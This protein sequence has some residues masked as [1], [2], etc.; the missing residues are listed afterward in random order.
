MYLNGLP[1]YWNTSTATGLRSPFEV[2]VIHWEWAVP[3]LLVGIVLFAAA[4][5]SMILHA[6]TLAPDVLGYVST[7]VRDSVHITLPALDSRHDGIER[8][9][10][11][12]NVRLIIGDVNEESSPGHI[13]IVQK[14][15]GSTQRLRRKRMDD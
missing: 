12:R 7:S 1:Y 14:V 2:Y 4:L 9:R 5:S 11:L 13:A 15:R 3:F 8:A 6:M 10:A